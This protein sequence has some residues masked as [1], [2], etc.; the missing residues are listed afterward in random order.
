M[1]WITPGGGGG[2][3]ILPSGTVVAETTL[4]LASS[5]GVSAAYSRGDH[6]HGSPANPFTGVVGITSSFSV[7]CDI[8]CPGGV[9]PALKSRTLGW[10]TGVLTSSGSCV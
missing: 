9:T 3:P 5:N 1:G 6:T 10:T 8:T 4:G 2:A 7:T